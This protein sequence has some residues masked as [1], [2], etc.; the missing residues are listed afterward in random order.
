MS[1]SLSDVARRLSASFAS[2][3]A[4]PPA[5]DH[6]QVR[7]A[8]QTFLLARFPV[9][10]ADELLDIV[11]EAVARL[12]QE[13][14]R[15]QAALEHAA[16]WLFVV[17]RREAIDRL[18]RDRSGPLEPDDTVDD[19]DALAAL[20]D[21]DASRTVIEGAFR[22]AYAANDHLAVRVVMAWL[23]T[24]DA[25]GAEPAS[26]ALAEQIGYSHTTIN[27]ALTRFRGYVAEELGR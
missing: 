7:A 11:D 18:R 21:R 17:A 5:G 1:E 9:L 19:D 23:D 10:A 3:G 15:Q 12:L 6:E 26:R 8:L 25:T 13:S 24:A 16:A 27:E 20:I 4:E 14:R 22:R 2:A